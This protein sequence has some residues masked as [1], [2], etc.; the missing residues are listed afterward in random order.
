MKLQLAF[1]FEAGLRIGL[2]PAEFEEGVAE[3]FVSA[4][5][6][7]VELNGFAKFVDSGFWKVTDGIGAAD[8]D[9][10]CGGILHGA[11]HVLKPLL[12]IR[13]ALG[14]Q[15][16][17]TEK[18]GGFEVIVQRDG[19][20]EIANGGGNIPAVKLDAAEDVLGAIVTRMHGDDGLGKLASFR[21]VAGTKPGDGSF[22]SDFRIG[23]SKFE[24]LIKLA[25]GFV[26]T[27][28]RNR[29]I[30][31]LAEAEGDGLVV[32]AFGFREVAGSKCGFGG[33]EITL[34]ESGG[35]VG[36]ASCYGAQHEKKG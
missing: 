23:G 28:F 14:F 3:K 25:S 2:F 26:E 9:M 13:E 20:L 21:E 16:G 6:L 17:K 33:F 30:G 10:Q 4:R 7:R 22:E 27:G 18:V 12:G 19:G 15:V 32:A 8:E 35:I 29:N 11:L 24:S 34:Q 31:D 36:G 1:E 5:I